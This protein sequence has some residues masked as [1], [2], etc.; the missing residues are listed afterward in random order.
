M[1]PVKRLFCQAVLCGTL[2][3][4]ARP[5]YATDVGASRDFGLGVAVGTATSIVGKYFLDQ[6]SA[7]DF[8]VSFWRFG[9]GCW[10][11][12]RGV[13]YCDRGYGYR[14]SGYGIHADYLWQDTLFRRR[15]K[16]D[17][18]IGA[19]GRLWVWDDYY[20]Y[21]DNEVAFAARM[22]IGMDLTFVRPDFLEV[23]AEVVPSL[24]V[25]PGT[26]IEME[27]FFGVRLYF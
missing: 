16:L 14:N 26:D 7:F 24:Y 17:W 11:D 2:L 13:A 9:R 8:G 22:P 27:G 19:G 25:V 12:N 3:L 1:N 20:A 23:Y 10:R 21:D 18:H 4:G 6:E 5:V 15:A